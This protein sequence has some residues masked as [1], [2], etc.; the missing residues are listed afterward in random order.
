ML[1]LADGIDL[2]S[3]YAIAFN[4][5]YPLDPLHSRFPIP[6]SLLPTYHQI[7]QRIN[8]STHIL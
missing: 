4:K 6:D 7:P 3:R 1:D 8:T 5:N 2:W